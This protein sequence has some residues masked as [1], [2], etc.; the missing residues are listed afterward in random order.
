[1]AKIEAEKEREGQHPRSIADIRRASSAVSSNISEPER[2][3]INN[4]RKYHPT[5]RACLCSPHNSSGAEIN[6]I[7]S[8]K[9]KGRTESPG[10]LILGQHH[11]RQLA[12]R[13][14]HKSNRC[15]LLISSKFDSRVTHDFA[16][17]PLVSDN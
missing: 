3:L 5:S 14:Q 16:L 10:D 8:W 17:C 7:C 11:L 6:V 2:L 1:M 13:P 9:T 12:V 4:K 15:P